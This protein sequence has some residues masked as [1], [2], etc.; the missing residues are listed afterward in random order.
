[1]AKGFKHGAGGVLNFKVICNPKPDTAKENTIWVDTDRINNYYFSATQPENMVD[2]DVWFPIGTSSPV[3]FSATKK[4]SIMVYPLSSKQYIGGEL[5]DKTAK[6]YQSGVWVEWYSREHAIA[7]LNATGWA[8]YSEGV[9]GEYVRYNDRGFT[10]ASILPA[11]WC[12]MVD[13]IY[14][15]FCL[16]ASSTA[17]LEKES[18]TSYGDT[19]SRTATT[20]SGNTV[21]II[22]QESALPISEKH[23][24][25]IIS[26]GKTHTLKANARGINYYNEDTNT[27]SDELSRFVDMILFKGV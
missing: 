25:D 27:L 26:D 13:D 10:R 24:M 15:G 23:S 5:V 7:D 9:A 2:Y 21:H 11:I 4:N 8:R 17:A 18:V 20:A 1:M 14:T 19:L 12:W 3:A 16:V 6:S 22:Y